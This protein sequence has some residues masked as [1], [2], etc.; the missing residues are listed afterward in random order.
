MNMHLLYL[1]LEV[2]TDVHIKVTIFRDVLP[3]VSLMG[4]TL[5]KKESYTTIKI[6]YIF[7]Y[8]VFLSSTAFLRLDSVSS[9]GWYLLSPE[10]G[11]QTS[12]SISL[13]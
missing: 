7:H 5:L 10:T 13:N 11:T 4:K 8:P 9:F 12:S 3:V 1:S 6:L 2:L